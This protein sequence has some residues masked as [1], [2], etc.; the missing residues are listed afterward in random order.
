MELVSVKFSGG[1]AYR[2]RTSLGNL[3]N[4]GDVKTIPDAMARDLCR[5]AEFSRL[6]ADDPTEEQKAE[7]IVQVEA[8]AREQEQEDQEQENMLLTI[9]S[10]DKSQLEA[11]ARN[12]EVELDKR[13]SLANLRLEVT[14]LVEQFGAR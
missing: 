5:F 4:P 6:E 2:D 11:Y 10:W 7:A 8:A 14:H 3:W 12:Y 1:R 9:E 13:K